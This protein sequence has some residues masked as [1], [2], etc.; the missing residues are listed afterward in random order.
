MIKKTGKNYYP[1]QS[2]SQKPPLSVQPTH[3]TTPIQTDQG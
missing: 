1:T 2:G 3:S